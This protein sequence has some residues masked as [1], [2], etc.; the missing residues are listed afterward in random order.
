[1]KASLPI[2][3]ALLCLA[4]GC[5]SKATA[6]ARAKAA[7]MAGRQQALSS[8]T[9]APQGPVVQVN[10]NVQNHQIPWFQGL[11]LIQTL[12]QAHYLGQGDPTQVSIEREGETIPVDVRQVMQGQDVP[13]QQDDIIEL[14]P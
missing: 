13:L 8:P 7:F 9:P 14:E 12:L 4:S 11:G 2:L 5:V 1:M 6:D 10:G 3:L